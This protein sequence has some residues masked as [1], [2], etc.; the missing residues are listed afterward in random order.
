MRPIWRGYRFWPLLVV[1]L[2]ACG[3]APEPTAEVTTPRLT[4]SG[5][6][7][8]DGRTLPLRRWLPDGGD[9]KALVLAVHGFGGFGL[10]FES[11]GE[12]LAGR[13]LGLLAPDQR[14]FGDNPDRGRWPGD[15][16]LLGDARDLVRAV[17]DAYP[18]TPLYLLGVSMGGAVA[19]NVGALNMKG[20]EGYI[21]A[22]PA[23]RGEGA[24]QPLLDGLLALASTVV[25]RLG[26]EVGHTDPRLTADA[27]RLYAD[28]P[29]VVRRMTV[30]HYH[31]ILKLADSAYA[32]AGR[33]ER[34]VLLLYGTADPILPP[35]AICRLKDKIRAPLEVRVFKGGVHN[36]LNQ[37]GIDAADPIAG[38]VQDPGAPL[39]PD[40]NTVPI[41]ALCRAKG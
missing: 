22:A 26:M 38:F 34:P 24:K 31:G 35:G 29:R 3:T 7:V 19:L 9:P 5:L 27:N 28:D 10:V 18:D 40:P 14:G 15:D 39:T 8:R 21:L 36:L 11:L 25:P 33:I 16:V 23:A 41:D 30:A 6:V 37:A 1:L 13:G 20:V 17:L 12:N 4:S 32:A 2:A